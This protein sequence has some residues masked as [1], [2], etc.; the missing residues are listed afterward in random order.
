MGLEVLMKGF[1]KVRLQGPKKGP[2]E[3]EQDGIFQYGQE[4]YT[5][6]AKDTNKKPRTWS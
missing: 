6:R 2:Q 4:E 5:L 1:F 3:G